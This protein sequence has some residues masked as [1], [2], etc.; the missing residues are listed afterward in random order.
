[1]HEYSTRTH[2]HS[3]TQTQHTPTY[4]KYK[5]LCSIKIN[6]DWGLKP[7]NHFQRHFVSLQWNV[8]CASVE[9][10]VKARSEEV[11]PWTDRVTYESTAVC[12]KY[13]EL[14][15]LLQIK[16][17]IRLHQSSVSTEPQGFFT[18]KLEE[19]RCWQ[20]NTLMHRHTHTFTC[21]DNILRPDM[22]PICNPNSV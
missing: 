5:Y 14:N 13:R 9:G 21:T 8:G 15:T 20:I 18:F 11:W 22:G 1:M 10:T 3:Q 17:L 4:I 7:W 16:T 6:T 2:T 19:N 12:P